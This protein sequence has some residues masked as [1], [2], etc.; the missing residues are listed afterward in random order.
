[1]LKKIAAFCRR[2]NAKLFGVPGRII[3]VPKAVI[4]LAIR[5]SMTAVAAVTLTTIGAIKVPLAAICDIFDLIVWVAKELY[6]DGRYSYRIVAGTRDDM[7]EDIEG[8]IEEA[9]CVYSA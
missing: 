1:M 8:E 4:V 5:I 7:V 3:A 6:D 2:W 9:E